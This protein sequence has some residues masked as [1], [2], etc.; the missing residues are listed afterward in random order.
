MH[1]PSLRAPTVLD[2]VFPSDAWS[3]YTAKQLAVIQRRLRRSWTTAKCPQC[4]TIFHAV[5]RTTQGKRGRPVWLVRCAECRRRAVLP[6]RHGDAGRSGGLVRWIRAIWPV[7]ATLLVAWAAFTLAFRV[8]QGLANNLTLESG[9]APSLQRRGMPLPAG[10]N[11]SEARDD[12]GADLR[13]SLAM[14]R[15]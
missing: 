6:A 1:K 7:A 15:R 12:N 9:A 8:A 5:M 2:G 4:R 14:A 10:L 13:Q 3:T 11:W